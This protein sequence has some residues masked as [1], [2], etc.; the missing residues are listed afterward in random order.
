MVTNFL[1][2]WHIY[3]I[4]QFRKNNINNPLIDSIAEPLKTRVLFPYSE[5]DFKWWFWIFL[6]V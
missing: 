5:H 1:L 3:G 4:D 2:K 6:I